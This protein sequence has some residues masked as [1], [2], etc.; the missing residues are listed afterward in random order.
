VSWLIEAQPI[1]LKRPLGWRIAEAGNADTARQPAFDS[2]VDEGRSDERH[3]DREID[4]N[5]RA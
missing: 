5:E 2:G 3:R 4:G 1:E